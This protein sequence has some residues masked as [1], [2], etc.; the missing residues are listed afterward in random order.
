MNTIKLNAE[1]KPLMVAHRGV[2]G[3][4]TENTAAAFVAAGNR[5]YYGIETDVH[6]TADGQFIIIHDDTTGRVAGGDDMTVEATSFE[7]LRR[8]TLINTVSGKKDRADLMCPSLAE[9]IA[10]CKKYEK[11]AVLELKN[12]FEKDDIGKIVE[13]IREAEYLDHVIFISFCYDNLVFLREFYPSAAAQYLI[14]GKE[15]PFDLIDRL[16]EH[17]FDLDI[18]HLLITADLVA[19]CHENGIEV[20]TWTVNT[21]EDAARVIAA[22]VDYITTNILE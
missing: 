9:Y 5:S 8:L 19:E 16:T 10:I 22:G 7:T 17:H 15:V 6:K 1:K 3:L 14:G 21:E 2:S 12:A 4:E 13:I 18:S 11:Y 20:N